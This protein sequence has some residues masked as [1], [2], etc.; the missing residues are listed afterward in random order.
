MDESYSFDGVA[1]LS[2]LL[3]LVTGGCGSTG[4]SAFDPEASGADGMAAHGPPRS[5]AGDA[6]NAGSEGGSV[7]AGSPAMEAGRGDTSTASKDAEAGSSDSS[8]YSTDTMAESKDGALDSGLGTPD[9][10]STSPDAGLEPA[11]A[12]WGVPVDGGP[13]FTGPT[14]AGTVNVTRETPNGKIGPGFA[15]FSFE[16]THMTNG[17]FTGTNAALIA[18]FKLVGPT[19]IRIGADDVDKCTWAPATQPGGGAPPYSYS[20]G[21]AEIDDL[22][23]MLTATGAKVIYGVNFKLDM[24]TNSAEEAAYAVT[25]LGAS[26]YGFEIGNELNH[27][28][29]WASLKTEWESFATAIHGMAAGAPLI[30]PAGSGNPSSLTAPFAASEAT[31]KDLILLTQHYYAGDANNATTGTVAQLLTADP[32]PATSPTGLRGTLSMTRTAAT[33]NTIPDGY[34]L[35]ECNSLSGH[36]ANGISNALI[37]ALWGL[38]MMFT[39]AEYGA[40]GV[41]FHGGEEGMDGTKPFY[42]SPIE[43]TDGVVTKANPLYDGMLLFNLAGTGQTLPTTATAGNLTFTAYSIALGDGSTSVVLINKDTTSGI[44]ATVNIGATAAHASAIY[45]QGPSP[46]SLTAMTGITVAGAGITAE[47][48][49]KREPPYA[50]TTSGDTFSVLVPPASAALVRAR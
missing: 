42:Y 26:L 17:T 2:L 45:L 21:T 37:S 20:I 13:A 24:P 3:A 48:E 4:P 41:N 50:L 19:V 44:R 15:G 33:T 8:A 39:A 6:P 9:S 40:G 36:G 25:K 30:G 10:T 49:W 31:G 38:D 1:G 5:E 29:S 35:G 11:D 34:R 7:D 18:L 22:T 28:G 46:A 43:E 32:L 47:G 16:K 23:D 14:V 12:G 27:Y